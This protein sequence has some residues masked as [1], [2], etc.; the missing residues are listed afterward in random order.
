[1]LYKLMMR[2][3]TLHNHVFSSMH[4][5]VMKLQ[6]CSLCSTC[7]E[8]YEMHIQG[9]FYMIQ[10][11]GL[12]LTWYYLNTPPKAQGGLKE[13]TLSL[14]CSS[15]KDEIPRGFVSVSITCTL[16][17]TCWILNF[18][19]MMCSRIKWISSLLYLV[20]MWRIGLWDSNTK[21]RLSHN[22][23]GEEMEWKAQV[24]LIPSIKY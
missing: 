2:M 24:V 8:V 10:L 6:P 17:G 18:F 16:L 12:Y 4:T 1:M 15:W 9:M 13:T 21:L 14:V 7:C 20:I 3:H 11:H 23:V 22:K 19:P 5:C